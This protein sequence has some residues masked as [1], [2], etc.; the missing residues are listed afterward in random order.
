MK[1]RIEDIPEGGLQINKDSNTDK[2]FKTILI[3]AFG[4]EKIKDDDGGRLNIQ[5]FKNNREITLIGGVILKVHFSCDRCLSVFQKQQQ[6]TIHQ[7]MLPSSE[8]KKKEA[9]SSDDEDLGFYKDN[10]IDLGGITKEY[11]IL[12]QHMVNLCSDDCKG[13]CP[14]CGKNLNAGACKCKCKKGPKGTSPF[15][16]LKNSKS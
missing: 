9:I 3:E 1:I 10:E 15:A 7:I 2:W 6:V 14:T 16:V 11:I 12:A 5:L 4:P 8:A 13:L